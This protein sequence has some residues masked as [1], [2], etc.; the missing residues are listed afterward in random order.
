[1]NQPSSWEALIHTL[2]SERDAYHDL[3]VLLIEEHP[4]LRS[5]DHQR[6]LEVNSRK[7]A[8]LDS[9]RH[10]EQERTAR[11][12]EFPGSRSLDDFAEWLASTKFSQVEEVQAAL[13]ELVNIAKRVKQQSEEN[14]GLTF[15]ALYIVREALGLIYS[16]LGT[17]PVYGDSGQ[18]TFPSVATSMNLKG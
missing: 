11:L 5:M 6:L 16:G 12:K 1:M 9:I 2:R 18:L 7:E 14:A 4:L 8:V 3:S 13:N 17:Q 10:L 15:R